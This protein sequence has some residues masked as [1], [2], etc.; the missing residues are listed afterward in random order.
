MV[1]GAVS[2]GMGQLRLMMQDQNIMLNA[3]AQY[4]ETSHAAVIE[5]QSIIIAGQKVLLE[6]VLRL[7]SSVL[8]GTN[9]VWKVCVLAL[10]S[11]YSRQNFTVLSY[12]KLLTRR[13]CIAYFVLLHVQ[14]L[15]CCKSALHISGWLAAS[16]MCCRSCKPCRL[17][18]CVWI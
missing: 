10:P 14:Q 3:I 9:K 4:L 8:D 6:E 7:H 17:M 18:A 2:E 15:A 11:A 1:L 12:P 13:C 16:L 5:G